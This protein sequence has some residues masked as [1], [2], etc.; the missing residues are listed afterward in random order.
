MTTNVATKYQLDK[1]TLLKKARAK[2]LSKS[3]AVKLLQHNK[4]SFLTKSYYGS[5][6]C[7]HYLNQSGKTLTTKYC[8]QRWCAVCNRIRTAHFILGYEEELKTFKNPY[9]VTLTRP[10]VVETDLVASIDLMGSVWREIMNTRENRK[11]KVK[12]IRKAECTIRPNDLYHYHFHVIIEGKENAEWLLKE[13]LKRMPK[14]NPK[15]QDMRKANERSLK[16][17][18][19]YFTKLTTKVGDKKELFAYARMDVIFR[20][21]YKKRVF[22]PF[23]GVKLFSEEIEDVTA[24]EYEHLEACEKVWKW[25]VD[26]WID[27]WGECLTGYTPSEEFKKFFNG[28]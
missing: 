3:L 8:K 11:R 23:G 24:Q 5:L 15:A 10:T 25:S 19:K 14:A 28:F 7:T 2:Y 18:F 1:S 4:D 22:Q 20:A 16:E 12:G 17:L 13:W 6:L 26:D 9:F 21:M 27:E